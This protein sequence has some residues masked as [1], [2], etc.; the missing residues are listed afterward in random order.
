MTALVVRTTVIEIASLGGHRT[1]W[2]SADPIACDQEISQRLR[3]SVHGATEVEQITSDRLGD[4]TL[5]VGVSCEDASH[6]R[7]DHAVVTK[8]RGIV[9]H[10]EQ[11][12]QIDGDAQRNR[13]AV[14]LG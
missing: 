9:G 10:A 7:R 13:T 5:P 6:R 2:E 8:L 12:R 4:E 11:A 3:W 1:T 14:L